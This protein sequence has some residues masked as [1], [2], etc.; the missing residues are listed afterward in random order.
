MRAA[1]YLCEEGKK[2]YLIKIRCL[3]CGVT[4]Y[5]YKVMKAHK[6]R[7]RPKAIDQLKGGLNT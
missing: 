4:Y 7:C 5:N 3:S 2:E 1:L 6:K